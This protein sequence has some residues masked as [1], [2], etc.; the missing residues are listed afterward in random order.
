MTE[1]ALS[2]FMTKGVRIRT[3][4]FQID[5]EGKIILLEARPRDFCFKTSSRFSNDFTNPMSSD[6]LLFLPL[7]IAH[8]YLKLSNGFAV[9]ARIACQL[10][11]NIAIIK[12]NRLALAKIVQV[13]PMRKAKFPSHLFMI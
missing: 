10:I 3:M 9:A 4:P 2:G 7:F 11:V 13:T 6:L 5:P 12:T 8:S 1:K